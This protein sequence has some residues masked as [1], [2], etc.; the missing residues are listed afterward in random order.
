MG[1]HRTDQR[2]QFCDMV[3]EIAKDLRDQL[4][5]ETSL[6]SLHLSIE[7]QGR[8]D[9]ELKISYQLGTSYYDDHSTT[10]KGNDLNDVV[11]E[12]I[13]RGGWNR[14]HAPLCIAAS[15][16]HQP[17]TKRSRISVVEGEDDPQ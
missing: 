11:E 4:S 5:K 12:F 17:K 8:V 10:T 2:E 13:R 14:N 15:E 3:A 1:I 7:V 6:S 16:E 9:G